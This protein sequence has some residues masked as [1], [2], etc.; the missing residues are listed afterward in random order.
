MP[1]IAFEELEGV[2]PLPADSAGGQREGLDL[3]LHPFSDGYDFPVVVEPG[4]DQIV[5]VLNTAKVGQ[6]E[7]Q[8]IGPNNQEFNPEQQNSVVLGQGKPITIVKINGGM[9]AGRWI[10]RVVRSPTNADAEKWT[11]ILMCL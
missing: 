9:L 8:L 11:W 4:V 7:L 10:V 5:F 2:E 6:L 1:S 3:R